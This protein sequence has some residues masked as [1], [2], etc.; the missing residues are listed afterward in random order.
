MVIVHTGGVEGVGVLGVVEGVS[1]ARVYYSCGGVIGRK[2][3]GM[4]A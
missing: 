2:C 4:A 3:V 1:V